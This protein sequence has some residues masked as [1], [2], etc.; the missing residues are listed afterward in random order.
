MSSAAT[1]LGDG[2]RSPDVSDGAVALPRSCERRQ[3]WWLWALVLYL[4]LSVLLF[5]LPVIGHFGSRIIGANEIDPSAD[6]WFLGWWPHAVLHGTN[7]FVTHAMF[8]P[9]GYNLQW[10]T[11]MPLLSL[12]CAPLTLVVGLAA[13]WNVVMLLSPALSAWTAYL[14]CRA[15]R[16]G[17]M[18]SLVGGFLFGF[19]PYVLTNLTGNPMLTMIPMI[20]VFALLVV[21]WLRGEMSDRRFVLWLALALSAQYLIYAEILLTSTLFGAIALLTGAVM[22][23][24]R[25]AAGAK[26][27]R[28]LLVAYAAAGVLVSPFLVAFVLGTHY[29]PSATTGFAGDLAWFI[30]PPGLVGPPLHW[31][32]SVAGGNSETYVG[33]PLVVIVSMALWQLRRRREIRLLGVCLL[34]A[35]IATLGTRLRVGG[36]TTGMWLPW[37]LVQRVPVFRYAIP[38][39]L[40]LFVML[41]A[42]LLAALWLSA[43]RGSSVLRWGLAALAIAFIA[44]HVGN[45][46]WHFAIADPPFFRDHTYRA[47]LNASDHVLTVPAWG[48]NERWVADAGFPFA[49]VGGYAGQHF[50]AGYTRFPTWNTLLTGRLTPDYAVQLRRFLAAKRVTAIVVQ[51]GYPGPWQQLFGTLGVT[52]AKLGGVLLY[53]PPRSHRL[54]R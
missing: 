34:A 15:L 43:R 18:P 39:R 36:H 20:P 17:T 3:A 38:V 53:L 4:T 2:V 41:F 8:Y 27:A 6:M 10:A 11:S 21:R 46:N 49:L 32:A 19:S 47:Y 33:L 28:L 40:G 45:P 30:Q 1:N 50:P 25:R 35:V 9:D 51:A 16:A 5:G 48:P 42:A 31:A 37:D 29:P 22:F 23:R 13:S 54:W 26:L 44:P 24:E 14:L 7:P 52:P 12:L